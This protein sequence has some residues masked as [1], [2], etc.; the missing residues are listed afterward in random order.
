MALERVHP[1]LETYLVAQA[2]EHGDAESALGLELEREWL[3]PVAKEACFKIAKLLGDMSE[4]RYEGKQVG[5]DHVLH[6]LRVGQD[7]ERLSRVIFKG[8]D[9]RVHEWAR[10]V[11]Y[12]HDIG[13][14]LMDAQLL[15]MSRVFSDDDREKMAVHTDIGFQLAFFADGEG[16]FLPALAAALHH[17]SKSHLVET[18]QTVLKPEVNSIFNFIESKFSY[19]P[20]KVS[21]ALIFMVSVTDGKDAAGRAYISEEERP[22]FTTYK[23]VM[24][25]LSNTYDA[26]WL[27]DLNFSYMA[28]IAN[29]FARTNGHASSS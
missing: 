25:W 10:V 5:K 12:A 15:D 9:P 29:T 19:L 13:K 18:G 1:P 8:N 26:S 23:G 7:M 21:E 11:G 6:S 28:R 2:I 20:K 17:H 27:P 16:M 3:D 14:I 22:D 4:I 24:T